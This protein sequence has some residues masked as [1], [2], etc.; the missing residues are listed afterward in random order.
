MPND[1]ISDAAYQEEE[2]WV[3]HRYKMPSGNILRFA[4]QEVHKERTGTHARI[5]ISVNWISLAYS[6]FNI[7]RD[8]DRVRIIN[9][10]F[11]QLD[12]KA[13]ELDLERWPKTH[14]KH[15]LDLFC[16]GLWDYA[17]QGDMGGLLQGTDEPPATLL[18]GSY[19]VDGGGTILFAPP[20]AGKSYP[21]LA[22]AVS[23][24]HGRDCIWKLKDTRKVIFINLERSQQSLA[25]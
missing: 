4:A 17:V 21:G 2:G 8:E 10:A 5:A 3:V 23:L 25:A 7:D 6:T 19:I 14:W 18:L 22:M 20:G 9:S 11:G 15:C 16:F 13:N 24:N 1:G 12:P